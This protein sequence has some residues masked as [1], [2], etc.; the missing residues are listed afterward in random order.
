VFEG[1][2][3]EKVKMRK[4]LVRVGVAVLLWFVVLIVVGSVAM[5][6]VF[7][8]GFWSILV[9]SMI[10]LGLGAVIPEKKES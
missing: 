3:G 10:F 8:V 4:D 1:E 6:D 5:L 7:I 2:R 9:L